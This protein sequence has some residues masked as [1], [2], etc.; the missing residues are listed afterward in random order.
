VT[1]VSKSG[2][3]PEWC[4]GEAWSQSV[5]WR[6]NN[7]VRGPREDL[8]KAIGK[9]DAIVSCVGSIGFDTQG[10]LLGNGKANEEVAKAAKKAG[11]KRFVYVSVSEEVAEAAS[12]ILP[13]YFTGKSI[14][15]QAILD[16]VGPSGAYFIKPS[17][18]YGG[19]GFGVFPPRVSTQYGAGV[20]GLLSNNAI[21]K[22]AD[23]LPGFAGL[24]KVAL[25][26]PVSVHAVAACCVR[27]ALGLIE[28]GTFEG[29][30]NINL[31]ADLPQPEAKLEEGAN[32]G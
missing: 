2:K 6:S 25:R 22:V 17:F 18:I 15:E 27:A 8:E 24:L 20:E 5:S 30:A 1:S 21:Q 23:V 4:A 3:V 19:D 7:L 16:A 12:D 14:A 28:P 13:G 29:T 11:V 10:L 32:V 26:P 9:P 31:A